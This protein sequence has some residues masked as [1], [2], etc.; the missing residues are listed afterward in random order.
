MRPGNLGVNAQALPSLG[1]EV[2]DTPLPVLIPWIPVLYSRV[3]DLSIVEGHQFYHGRVQLILVPHGGG[4]TFQVAHIAT[5][6]GNDQRPLELASIGCIDAEVG[7]KLH[8]AADPLRDI[9]ERAIAEDRGVQCSEEV[10]CVR[11]HRS[12]V[13]LNQVRMVQDGF[14][15]RTENDAHL[16]QLVFEGSG[17]RDAVKD[18]IHGDPAQPLLFLQGNA[19]L[20][21]SRQQL[22]V[23]LFQTVEGLLLLGSRIV[24]DVLIVNGWEMDILPGWLL[25]CQPMPVGFQTPLQHELGLVFLSGN[26]PNDI[27]VQATRYGIGFN[28]RDKSPLI[29]FIGKFFNCV[30]S[31][32]HRVSLINIP[33]G[34][35]TVTL[36]INPR[37]KLTRCVL[38]NQKWT[39]FQIL[40][41]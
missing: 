13:L 23:N 20:L 11:H 40:R 24:N 27:L 39:L 35:G 8:R 19:Q 36:V 26:H 4:A 17:H 10:I 32:S 16:R 14:R 6:L 31:G 34:P 22:R 2:I 3:L 21:I 18:S 41:L 33:S 29:F 38:Q 15:E 7:G 30:G 37:A 5:F 28:F 9:A 25:H 1:N 12:K